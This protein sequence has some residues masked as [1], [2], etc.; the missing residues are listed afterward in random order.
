MAQKGTPIGNMAVGLTLDDT[1]FGNTLDQINKQVKLADS[2]MKANM[3]AIGDAGK[4]YDGLSVKAKSLQDVIGAQGKKVAELTKRYQEEVKANGEASDQAKRLAVEV[5]NAQAKMSG[6]EGQ[7]KSTKRELAY[8]EQGMNELSQ[9]MKENE[10]ET[11]KNTRALKA[12]GDEAGA[13]ETQQKGLTKQL[14]LTEQ[15]VEGQRKVVAQLTKEFGASDDNTKKAAR[16]LGTLESQAKVTNTQLKSLNDS[17]Q[18]FDVSAGAEKSSGSFKGLLGNVNIFKGALVGGFVTAGIFAVGK[19]FDV[20]KGSIGSAIER[21]DKI[22]TATKSLTQL[23]GSAEKAEEIMKSVSSV[24]KGTPIAMDAMTES[25]KGLIASG[26]KADK[27]EGVLRATTDAA[28]GLGK[29]EES[30][31][32]ISDAFKALQASGTASLGDLARLTDAN[33][34]AIKILANQYGMSVEDMKKKITSGALK[35]EEVINK[36]VKGMEKG[37]KGSNGAT[38]ALAGQAK[39][40]GD[41]ISGSF[42]NMKSAINRSIANIITPFKDTLIKGMTAG[43]ETIEKVFGGLGANVQKSVDVISGVSGKIKTVLG[44]GLE[45]E[46]VDI[47]SKYFDIGT[48]SAII[49]NIGKIKEKFAD[50][51]AALKDGTGNVFGSFVDGFNTMKTVVMSAMPAIKSTITGAI[52]IFKAVFNTLKPF[53]MPIITQIVDIFKG[54]F[55]TLK[56]FWAENGTMIITAIT[57][58]IKGIQTAIQFILPIIKPVLAVIFS[59]ISGLINNIKGVIQGGL[60]VIMGVVKIF[61]G[62]FTGNFSKMWEGI[63]QVFAGAIKF[64]WNAVNLLFVGR[65]LKGVKVLAAGAKTVISGMWA[66]IKGFFANGISIVWN[67]FKVFPTRILNGFKTLGT[68]AK[69]TVSNMW[70][71]IKGFFTNGASA[72]W[73]GMKSLPSKVINLFKNMKDG[74]FGWVKKMIDNVKSMPG[75]MANGIKNGAGALRDKFKDMFVSVVKVIAKPV[76]G[77][78]GGINW[79]LDK[80]GASKLP[81]WDV[82]AYARG[83]DSHPGGLAMINDGKGKNYKEAVQNP[84]GSTFIAQG[85]NV[86]MP[87]QKGAKVLNGND[88]Q[89]LMQQMGMPRYANGIGN[90]FSGAW[91][92]TKNVASKAWGATKE[93]AGDIWDYAKNPM[94]IVKDVVNS[95]L[96]PILGTMSKAPLSIAKG[97]VNT[98]FG[99]MGNWIKGIFEESGGAE[100]KGEGVTRWT[101]TVKRALSM[102]NLPTSKPYV[103]AWLRQI[104][105]ESG[106]NPR[107]VQG[108]IG[109]INNK[110]G[111]LAKGLVQ[112]IGTTF[113]AYKFPGHGNRLN[114]L[115]SLLAGIN[116][117][118][119]RYGASGMLNVV[120]K[121]HGYAN[122]GLIT[123]HQIAEIGEGNKPEMIIP[124]SLS[125]RSRAVQLLNKT[126]DIM[127]V[128]QAGQ[129]AVTINN[130]G[131]NSE[132]VAL[133]TQ[134][135]A[136]LM[137]LVNK[138]NSTYLDGKILH[139]NNSMYQRKTSQKNNIARG[140]V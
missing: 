27:V 13:F 10:R 117:A 88:T 23:T 87:L 120:G 14:D 89:S 74:V 55:T 123:Q 139:E 69:N 100:P 52:T 29:G 39:T 61:A 8:A 46:K 24:I 17:G 126:M 43:G 15:A 122:G 63:K 70:N 85:R 96:K 103:N 95:T 54:I 109:D 76:N 40:A 130:A 4:S 91:D 112:V 56:T 38:I 133:L 118:K 110:T 25:T 32:Q 33:V 44:N 57:N 73:N 105:S 35:S 81:T 108:N 127:G 18:S 101:N 68:G 51:K 77:I 140:I 111:D 6:Y 113:E 42:A 58:V 97:A 98:T 3:K 92:S 36:L 83:T 134:Q 106:G 138:D 28:Y 64:V 2:A 129:G 37:T 9:E 116:Y 114:G 78:L 66:G 26:M 31:G 115:D 132:L 75:K 48:V 79:V 22:D 20:I 53:I 47:L 34:P 124:L 135:N 21:I 121:G 137:Q 45:G 84:D 30:I 82:P 119:S 131:D 12:A 65:I 16:A 80:V 99:G 107:A 49:D 86:V 67:G 102:N 62:L 59:I 94:S 104:Q 41:S 19:A 136:L 71:G 90:W 93:F 72:V 11:T 50:F 5:N 7:L 128:K 125:K 60:S 1:Q